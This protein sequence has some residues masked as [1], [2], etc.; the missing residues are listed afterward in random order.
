MLLSVAVVFVVSAISWLWFVPCYVAMSRM[1]SDSVMKMWNEFISP[2]YA[3][4][5]SGYLT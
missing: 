3:I 2:F 1:I 4:L 5:P